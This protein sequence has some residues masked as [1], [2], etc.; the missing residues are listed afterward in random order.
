MLSNKFFLG[1]AMSVQLLTVGVSQASVKFP[2]THGKLS[3]NNSAEDASSFSISITANCDKPGGFNKPY[4][5]CGQQT[6]TAKVNADGTFVMSKFELKGDYWDEYGYTLS[7]NGTV[8]LGQGGY[9]MA[10]LKVF[11]QFLQNITL[12]EIAPTAIHLS[13]SSGLAYSD[14]MKNVNFDRPAEYSIYP[15]HPNEA[16]SGYTVYDFSVNSQAPDQFA[17]ADGVVSG[18]YL[19]AG[20]LAEV[21]KSYLW[22]LTVQTSGD[23]Y[24][25]I[26]KTATAPIGSDTSIPSSLLNP[27]ISV[28]EQTGFSGKWSFWNDLDGEY[29][30]DPSMV[31]DTTCTDGVLAGTVTYRYSHAGSDVAAK[32]DHSAPLTGTC[33]TGVADFDLD[34]VFV[35]TPLTGQGSL[36]DPQHEDHVHMH[37]T[38][39]EPSRADGKVTPISGGASLGFAILYQLY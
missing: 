15:T 13:T 24:S 20:T 33:G 34:Y 36:S 38:Q 31:I 23:P 21:Q 4:T 1:F 32:F 17:Q 26:F 25:A 16:K 37:V 11:E 3:F 12:L 10:S 14:W 39:K 22:K 18:N 5:P 19:C 29:A 9:Y 6:Q 2:E 8:V 30:E 28:T 35:Q 27:V 7:K